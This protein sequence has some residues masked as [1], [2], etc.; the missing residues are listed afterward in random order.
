MWLII[1]TM[2]LMRSIGT[3]ESFVLS[4][5]Q[6]TL[7]G[8][9]GNAGRGKTP[10]LGPVQSLFCCHCPLYLAINCLCFLRRRPWHA[11]TDNMD[12][13]QNITEYGNIHFKIFFQN[14]YLQLYKCP[15]KIWLPRD[16]EIEKEENNC[17]RLTL[18]TVQIFKKPVTLRMVRTFEYLSNW[19]DD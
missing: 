4:N 18:F 14:N 1:W 11:S 13:T 15:K 3:L 2:D 7:L 8:D 5:G 9:C 17:Y 10:K 19:I 12:S 6:R 16:Q